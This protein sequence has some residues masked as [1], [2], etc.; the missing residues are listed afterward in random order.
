MT[1]STPEGPSK[2]SATCIIVS[3]KERDGVGDGSR[4]WGVVKEST[5]DALASVED[6]PAM[7]TTDGISFHPPARY[8]HSVSRSAWFARQPFMTLIQKLAQ[9]LAEGIPRQWGQ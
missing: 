9:G 6:R 7:M 1:L 8:L 2:L 5:T 3:A 4:G